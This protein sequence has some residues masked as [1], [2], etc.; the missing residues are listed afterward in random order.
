MANGL[1]IKRVRED[2]ELY[3]SFVDDIREAIAIEQKK[4]ETA[5]DLAEIYRAQGGKKALDSFLASCT[6]TEREERAYQTY[7]RIEKG[8]A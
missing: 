5:T 4:T 8:E 1:W 2:S 7:Q 3:A 6:I